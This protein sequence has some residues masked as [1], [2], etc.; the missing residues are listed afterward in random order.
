MIKDA[1]LLQ[2]TGLLPLHLQLRLLIWFQTSPNP[3]L[4]M[5]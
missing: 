1:I 5:D 4:E 2:Q 3:P